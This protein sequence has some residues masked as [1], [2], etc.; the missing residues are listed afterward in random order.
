MFRHVRAGALRVMVY[1]GVQKGATVA[2]GG[3]NESGISEVQR[4]KAVGAHDLATADLVLTTY[5]ILRADMFHVASATNR[6]QRTFRQAK[7]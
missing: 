6:N 4:I 3:Q 1:E 5:D 2:T 7:R